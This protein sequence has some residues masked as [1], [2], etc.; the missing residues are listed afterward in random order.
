[1]KDATIGFKRILGAVFL[2]LARVGGAIVSHPN[3]LF[4]IL[5]VIISV[6]FPYLGYLIISC[7]LCWAYR[8][9]VYS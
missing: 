1:M 9:Y 5:L 6:F 7:L 2:F 8:Q 4:Y 3:K